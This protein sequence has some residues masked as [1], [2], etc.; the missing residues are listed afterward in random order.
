MNKKSYQIFCKKYGA[1]VRPSRERITKT[2][3]IGYNPNWYED[4]DYAD[5]YL[6]THSVPAVEVLLAEED[7]NKLI[8]VVEEIE[9]PQ[10][11]WSQFEYYKKRLGPDFISRAIYQIEATDREQRIRA[12]VPALQKAW[13]NYQLLLSI[14]KESK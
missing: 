11:D 8:N 4:K 14:S 6:D 9:N 10:S 2:T 7:F 1:Q 3:P 5:M 13:E 12:R